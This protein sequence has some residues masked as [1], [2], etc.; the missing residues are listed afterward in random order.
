MA[1]PFQNRFLDWRWNNTSYY[2]HRHHYRVFVWTKQSKAKAFVGIRFSS[3]T[4]E[5]MNQSNSIHQD[6]VVYRPTDL[7]EQ[8]IQTK[9]TK[10]L[11]FISIYIMSRLVSLYFIVFHFVMLYFILVQLCLYSKTRPAPA[12]FFRIRIKEFES[13]P[14]EFLGVVQFQS[15]QI[16]HR[17]GVDHAL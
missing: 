2:M 6:I 4:F 7:S 8:R 9:S 5:G 16:Q 13:T 14:N 10:P 12:A 17:L 3:D 1:L 15:I 11:A